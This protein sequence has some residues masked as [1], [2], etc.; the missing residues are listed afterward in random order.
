MAIPYTATR[1]K[2]KP[3][4][5]RIFKSLCHIHCYK[6]LTHPRAT[7]LLY[8]ETKN[9]M[10]DTSHH[11]LVST[12]AANKIP[13]FNSKEIHE[14]MD[15][16]LGNGAFGTV[17]SVKGHPNLAVKE[18]KID[19][20]DAKLVEIILFEMATFPMFSHPGILKYHQTIEDGS[21]IY[22]IMDRYHGNLG[23]LIARYA[24]A[25]DVIPID[26]VF[27][28]IQQISAALEYLH[29]SNKVSASGKA[30]PGVVHRDLKPANI[31]V[32]KDE[33]HFVLADFGLCKDALRDGSTFAGTPVYMAP[34]TLLHGK[35]ST[36]SDIWALGVII[37]ELTTLRTLNFTKSNSPKDVFVSGWRPDLS[38]IK[39][40]AIRDI[41]AKIFVLNPADRPTAKE[42]SDMFRPSSISPISQE[43]QLRALMSRCRSLEL[44]LDDANS[45]ITFLERELDDKSSM[46]STLETQCDS[47]VSQ[48][49]ALHVAVEHGQQQLTKPGRSPRRLLTQRSSSPLP[50]L[51]S[52]LST[53]LA[54]TESSRS[55]G[56]TRDS[57]WT[58]LMVAAATGNI[59]KARK[60]LADKDVINADGDTAFTIAARAG[61]KDIVELL[62]PTDE[63][64]VTALMRAADKGDVEA[65]KLLIPLQKGRQAVEESKINGWCVSGRTALMGAAAYGHAEVVKLL[66]DHEGR[67][68]DQ[69]GSSA[70]MWAVNNNRPG[71]VPLLLEKEAGIQDND[72]RTALVVAVLRNYLECA[73]FLVEREACIQQDNGRTALM[74]AAANNYSSSV[75]LLLEKE[76]GMQ[77]NEGL[78]ALML[79]AHS[80]NLTC[81]FLLMG[82]EIGMQDKNGGTALIFAVKENHVECVKLLLGKE[83]RI[84]DKY[85]W[86]ALME[87]A[88]KNNQE[89]V[90][91]LMGKEAGM[92]DNDGWTA[93][94]VAAFWNHPDC[95]SLLLDKEKRMQNKQSCTALMYAAHK[96]HPECAALLVKEERD[97]RT[98]RELFGFQPGSTALD[99]A[100]G[101]GHHDV[102]SILSE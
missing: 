34:E 64:G 30:L 74:E 84:A 22:I 49:K 13:V 12:R 76:A 17:H 72:G 31:L 89:C 67:M 100:R 47:Y 99:I 58:P 44:A 88:E 78:S 68:R 9:S 93:L 14:C 20:Q 15:S 3:I 42:L 21:F 83:A 27:S 18:I 75:K 45:K 33:R 23:Y 59:K 7:V 53:S 66:V 79:A 97:V 82:K 69:G 36:A 81:V 11:T 87:A 98:T 80:N 39:D 102:V 86:T 46:V 90:K 52:S 41:L 2:S 61:N 25:N 60:Y 71:C 26:T 37:Y 77:D 16:K 73:K 10:T 1:E 29:D 56:T 32:S 85:G 43:F 5:E 48:I 96:N 92:Q 70:L 8:F 50:E 94:I 4:T 28:I 63:T 19:G 24:R 6:M 35:T 38:A 62:D 40:S 51:L 57:T 54:S 65:V 55:P 91:L 101:M 95:V